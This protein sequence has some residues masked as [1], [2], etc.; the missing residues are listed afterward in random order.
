MKLAALDVG[1]NTV[2]MLAVEWNA[3]QEPRV[4]ADWSRITRLGRGVDASGHLDPE[5]AMRTLEAIAEFADRARQ[6]GVEKIVGAATAALRDASDG[7]EFLARVRQRAGIALEIISGQTEAEL[8][9]L[10]TRKGLDLSPAD[11]LLIVDIGGGSTELIRAE[12]GR[13]LDVVSLQLGSVRL[14]ERFI[15]HD[16]PH[17]SEA[18]MMRSAVDK[19]LHHLGWNYQ[20]ARMVGIAGTVTTLCAIALKLERYAPEAV[21]GYRLGAAEI[22]RLIEL[23]GSLPLEQRQQLPGMEPG[24]ADV[25]FAGAI[26]LER[27]MD[28]FEGGEIIVSD[29]GVRWGLMWREVERLAPAISKNLQ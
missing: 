15:H 9:Y 24:R 14:T 26:I 19:E 1:S 6:L 18:E 21:H 22:S 16:P 5:S 28:C 11:K 2:L 4:L 7:A 8:S 17:P 10:S 3:E 29:Q 13:A 27:V 12:P 23:L 20:P 25:L